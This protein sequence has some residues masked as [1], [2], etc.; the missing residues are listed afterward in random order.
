MK[1]IIDI[2]DDT[3]IA[4]GDRYVLGLPVNMGSEERLFPTDILL[5]PYVERPD[6]KAIEDEVWELARKIERMTV[7][8]IEDCFDE[9]YEGD[10]FVVSSLSYQEAKAMYGAWKKDKDED[11]IHIGDE[12]EYDDIRFIVTGLI[13]DRAYGF[14]YPCDYDDVG[15][16][17]DV[18]ML[19]K[20]G[21]HFD[22]VAELLKKMRGSE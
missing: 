22:E 11:E 8:E 20:T 9:V 6:R 12:V 15:E 21:R 1:Y 14:K 5:T 19:T 18:D 2:P 3:V 16:Y 17:C 4:E 13:G 10:P 7:G